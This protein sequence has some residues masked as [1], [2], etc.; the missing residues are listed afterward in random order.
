MNFGAPIFTGEYDPAAIGAFMEDVHTYLDQSVLL[1]STQHGRM[2][3]GGSGADYRG[4]GFFDESLYAYEG[5]W[6]ERFIRY[7]VENT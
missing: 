6:E 1:I 5:T 7:R 2:T 4:D 3:V